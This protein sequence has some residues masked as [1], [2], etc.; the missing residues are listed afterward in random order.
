MRKRHEGNCFGVHDED[1]ARPRVCHFLH[2][3]AS[4]MTH[5]AKD[6]KDY[7]APIQR[8]KA[9]GKGYISA[10]LEEVT[11]VLV[12]GTQC[13]HPAKSASI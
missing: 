13:D 8:G 11:V 12:E 9:V 3:D 7:T 2:R 4:H 10:V 1:Q 6:S 5:V